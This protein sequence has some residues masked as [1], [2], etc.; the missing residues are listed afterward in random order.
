MNTF[1]KK[2]CPYEYEYAN[3]NVNNLNININ[4]NNHNNSDNN[5]S[6]MEITGFL[7]REWRD[8]I[9]SILLNQKLGKKEAVVLT[10]FLKDPTILPSDVHG[11]FLSFLYT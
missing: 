4:Y 5:K 2:R 3:S 8:P 7:K 10:I 11:T 9:V 1:F 6:K